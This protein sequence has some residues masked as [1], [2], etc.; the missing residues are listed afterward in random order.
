MKLAVIVCLVVCSYLCVVKPVRATDRFFTVQSIDT[1]KYS[2]DKARQWLNDSRLANEIESQVR[3]IADTGATHIAVGTP[4]DTEFLPYLTEWVQVARERHL[5]VWFRGNFAGWEGW[6]MYPRIDRPTHTKRVVHFIQINKNLFQNGD[7]FSACPECE[8]GIG[9]DPRHSGDLVGFRSFLI[10]EHE[11]VVKAFKS[12]G[13]KVNADYLSMNTDVAK[14]VMDQKTRSHFA[15]IVSI[16]HYVQTPEKLTADINGL[17][18]QD[19]TR[20]VLSEFGVPIPDING[21]M[22]EYDQAQWID[23]ALK[24]L[25][26]SKQVI[27]VNYWVNKSG[28]TALWYEN[29]KSKEAVSTL[30]KYFNPRKVQGVIKNKQGEIIDSVQV[31]TP[32]VTN[33]SINGRY[34]LPILADEAITFTKKGYYS[35]TYLP[36]IDSQHVVVVNVT[37][38]PARRL[39][40][41]EKL[42]YFFKKNTKT[43]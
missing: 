42:F 43:S 25:I 9:Q 8:N 18:I 27:A 37:L 40:F 32:F 19:H 16:D 28:S 35:Y 7:I 21:I 10:S 6:F 2:R 24:K 17:V 20:V 3:A 11:E 34:M 33:Y 38:Q 23:T 13:V 1:M 30:T 12:I 14:L 22:S 36:K 5:S 31:S 15:N 26:Q 4:Y 41:F 29:G 39:F